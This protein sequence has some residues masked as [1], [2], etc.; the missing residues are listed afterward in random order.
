[1][2]HCR[3]ARGK[4]QA[5]E[6][7]GPWITGTRKRRR[8]RLATAA[9][10]TLRCSVVSAVRLSRQPARQPGERRQHRSGFAC[11]R[12]CHQMPGSNGL[13]PTPL[14]AARSS[15]RAQ[16]R[17]VQ[18]HEPMSCRECKS[19]GLRGLRAAAAVARARP[20][21][22]GHPA[23]RR[24]PAGGRLGGGTKRTRIR[25]AAPAPVQCAAAT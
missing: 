12:V 11:R 20:R 23:C 15:T 22:R 10:Y 25:A 21:R 3:L 2:R 13:R 18:V 1:M 4:W 5:P 7:Q 8:K 19:P 16:T 17:N 14:S 9:P 24:A 6:P